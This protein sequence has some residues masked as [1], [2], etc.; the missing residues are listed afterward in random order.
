[1]NVQHPAEI[2]RSLY[3]T[4]GG[5]L[6]LSYK[7]VCSQYPHLLDTGTEVTSGVAQQYT[8]VAGSSNQYWITAYEDY[9]KNEERYYD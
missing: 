8:D 4:Q 2:L 6:T 7:E 9:M 5:T 1:M 3:T